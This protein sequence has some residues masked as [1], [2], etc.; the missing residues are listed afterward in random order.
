[1]KLKKNI[2]YKDGNQVFRILVSKN[3]VLLIE[4]R[5]TE[6]RQ[7]YYHSIDLTSGKKIF[8]KLQL[9]E[10]FWIGVEKIVDDVII[11][12]KYA[13]PDMPGHN[14]VIAVNVRDGKVLWQDENA[15]FIAAKSERIFC[16]RKSFG[17]TEIV[18]L[19]LLSGE[20]IEVLGRDDA[21]AEK[22]KSEADAEEDYSDYIFPDKFTAD[23]IDNDAESVILRHT[24]DLEI[25]GDI[26]YCRINNFLAANFHSRIKDDV[27]MNRFFAVD[28][29]SGKELLNVVLNSDAVMFVPDS[30][31]IYKNSLILIKEKIEVFVYK[32]VI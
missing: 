3:D 12:H 30:F 17:L 26:E 11:F 19:N 14:A 4:T 18:A 10:K 8:T 6:A 16:S 15:E 28:L 27:L 1:M 25:I 7:V 20:L 31:F 22:L 21:I 9:D 23:S 24:Q 32:I 5:D 29:D 13:K 2:K